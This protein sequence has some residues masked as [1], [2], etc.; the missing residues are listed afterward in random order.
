MGEGLY[1]DKELDENKKGQISKNMSLSRVVEP[2]GVKSNY[3]GNDLNILI[4]LKF[5]QYISKCNY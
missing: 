3:F 4:K 5:Y 2:K 1:V